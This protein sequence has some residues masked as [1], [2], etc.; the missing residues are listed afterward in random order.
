M[1]D[2]S[3][4]IR[5]AKPLY[6]ARKRRQTQIRSGLAVLAVFLGISLF[7]P[8]AGPVAVYSYELADLDQVYAMM[9][10]SAVADLGLPVDEY[11]L[12]TVG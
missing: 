5:E 11:G 3:K 6:F 10:G 7:Y 12:L 4:L 2:I 9:E 8:S 1:D